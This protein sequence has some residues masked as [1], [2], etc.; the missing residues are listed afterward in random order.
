MCAA[1]HVSSRSLRAAKPPPI[2]STMKKVLL[3]LA[4]IYVLIHVAYD[5]SKRGPSPAEVD[6]NMARIAAE[7][8][9]T[10]PRSEGGMRIDN[11]E[12][13]DRVM[14]YT[15]TLLEGHELTDE[16]RRAAEAQLKAFYC[17]NPQISKLGVGVE[18]LFKK[19]GA[20]SISDKVSTQTWSTKAEPADC[21]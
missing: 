3:V 1:S 18:Y 10:L 6:T 5:R 17:S 2:M 4:V 11:V 20:R 14:R 16:F 19:T 12:Y 9:R 15:G 13:A 8:S 21:R 7:I